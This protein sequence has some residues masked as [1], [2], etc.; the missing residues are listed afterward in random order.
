M[1]DSRPQ[2]SICIPAYNRARH[3]PALL[4]SIYAQDV[5]DFEIVICEDLSPERTSIAE[6]SKTYAAR[7]PNTLRYFENASNLGYDANIRNLVDRAAG[8]YCFFMG[9]DDLMCREALKSVANAVNSN[10]RIGY[11]LRS[12]AWFDDVPERISQQI[13]YFGEAR[14]LPAGGDTISLCFR[15]AGVISGIVLH[16]DAAHRAA[17]SEFDGTLFYQM[18]LVGEV[19]TAMN[20][21]FL[22]QILVLCR[23]SEPPEFGNSPNERGIYTPGSYTPQARLSMVGGALR[24]AKALEDRRGIPILSAIMRDY[25]N[26][27]YPYIRDQLSLPLAD[28]WQLYRAYSAMGFSR[29]PMFHIYCLVC[30]LLGMRRFDRAVALIRNL[31]GRSPHFGLIN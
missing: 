17:T 27:F 23:N 2:F 16:R 31:L 21:V 8:E 28:F 26:Y 9:N 6:I 18:H 5:R 14:F 22:P 24:I 7:H 1:T 3:L 30:Y 29:Y 25:A 20:A 13:R 12:Y 19:L 10:P 11:V 15:R 4:D